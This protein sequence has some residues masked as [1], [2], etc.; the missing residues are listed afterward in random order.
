MQ[1]F[2]VYISKS[3]ISISHLKHSV[4]F[5]STKSHLKWWQMRK[6]IDHFWQAVAWFWISLLFK[7]F[8]LMLALKSRV[9]HGFL[10]RLLGQIDGR[11]FVNIRQ[12]KHTFILVNQESIARENVIRHLNKVQMLAAN[13]FNQNLV[14]FKLSFL[15]QSQNLANIS[16][17][18][19]RSFIL[20]LF[21]FLISFRLFGKFLNLFNLLFFLSLRNLSLKC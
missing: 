8:G 15:S 13:L 16:R 14:L 10:C 6:I 11:F 4:L 2:L 9:V 5:G 20:Q 21:K 17:N 7:F 1:H 12:M 18:H 19:I 3:L